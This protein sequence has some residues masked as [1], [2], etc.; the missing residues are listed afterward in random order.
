QRPALK[1]KITRDRQIRAREYAAMIC[2]QPDWQCKTENGSPGNVLTAFYR[3]VGQKAREHAKKDGHEFSL[4]D[5]QKTRLTE[6]DLESLRKEFGD[7]QIK[8]AWP[9]L[10]RHIAHEGFLTKSALK[11]MKSGKFM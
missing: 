9:L 10:E 4:A 11:F 8:K 7:D 5:V 1:A 3:L 6:K 2:S